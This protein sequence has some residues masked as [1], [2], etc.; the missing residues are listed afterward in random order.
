MAGCLLAALTYFPLFQALTDAAN[1][2][3][4]A[5]QAK[6]KV[7]RPRRSGELLV[8]VQPD[9]REI[10]FHRHATSPSASWRKAR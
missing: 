9:R 10:E 1:P 2:A 8:P 4:A 6:N 3:L 5:A 7:R